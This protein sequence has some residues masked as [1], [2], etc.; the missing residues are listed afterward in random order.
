[1]FAKLALIKIS[2]LLFVDFQAH[3]HRADIFGS[4]IRKENTLFEINMV[5][6]KEIILT[7]MYRQPE[8][9]QPIPWNQTLDVRGSIL[10]T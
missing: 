5:K 8:L 4:C 2:R 3:T 6:F 10:V 9:P 1:M 7:A